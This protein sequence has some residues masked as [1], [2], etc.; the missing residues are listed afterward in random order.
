MQFLTRQTNSLQDWQYGV[1]DLVHDVSG[2]V[3]VAE[4]D[5]TV[6]DQA[7]TLVEVLAG[8]DLLL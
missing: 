1:A 8:A 4:G 2:E 7:A 3:C 6:L 5:D